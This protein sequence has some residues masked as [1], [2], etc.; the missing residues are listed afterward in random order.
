[1]V[2]HN[3]IKIWLLEDIVIEVRT[4]SH[5]NDDFTVLFISSRNK[6]VKEVPTLGRIGSSSRGKK[7]FKLINNQHNLLA[8]TIGNLV[9][10]F[11]KATG[12]RVLKLLAQFSRTPIFERRGGTCIS[13]QQRCC[14]GL[15][16][17][18]KR[19]LTWFNRP[20]EEQAFHLTQVSHL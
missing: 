6:Q 12:I 14:K 17:S 19:L 18:L 10:Q 20:K 1:M 4:H 15:Y 13:I 8:W 5:D 2:P 9:K 16:K 7:F 3:L 11:M